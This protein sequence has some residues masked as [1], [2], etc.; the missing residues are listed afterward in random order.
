MFYSIEGVSHILTN[1][2]Y[3]TSKVIKVVGPLEVARHPVLVV[4]LEAVISASLNVESCQIKP[5][6][7][8][9]L[10]LE[11]V[12]GDLARHELV[13]KLHRGGHQT[14]HHLVNH[15]GLVQHVGVEESIPVHK[16][17]KRVCT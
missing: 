13:H 8:N 3:F 1:L 12:V 15:L 4:G 9:V 6:F 10:L 17:V 2:I 11:Q 5:G 16:I 7:R 14:P